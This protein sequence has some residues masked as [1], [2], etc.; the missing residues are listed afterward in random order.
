MTQR[1]AVL[2]AAGVT[3]AS[4]WRH[5]AA[6]TGS[7]VAARVAAARDSETA[8]A[9]AKA[10]SGL[11][12]LE[13][14]AW[15]GLAAAWTVAT[16]AGAPLAPCLKRFSQ[17]LRDLAQTQRDSKVALAGPIAT[18]RMV[19][20][21]PAVGVLFG[22]VLGFNT[23]ATLFTTPIG[24][25]CLAVGGIL[26]AAALRWNRSLVAKAR[27]TDATPGIG[28]DLM[29]IAVSGG[30]SLDSARAIVDETVTR[31]ALPGISG[32]DEVLELSRSAGVPAA[33]LLHSEAEEQRRVATAHAQE[34]AATLTVTL[35]LP[36]GLC[37]LPAFMVL[38]VF[39]LLVTVISSTAGT[40]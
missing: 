29:A 27:P 36:L 13:S 3:P 40:F 26:I 22:M 32:V 38:G 12:P 5:V 20:V 30:S 33:E 8:D 25:A 21:L 6:S 10:A 11:D 18:A 9:V 17:S 24:W 16:R 23:L 34:N 19:V 39:P 14:G 37:I 4:A 15:R 31:F 2:L 28:C 1:L 7:T 35:M